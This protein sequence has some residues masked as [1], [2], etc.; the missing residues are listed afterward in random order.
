MSE[1]KAAGQAVE[2][3]ETFLRKY[4][5]YVRPL[6]AKLEDGRWLVKADVGALAV[7]IAK[8]TIDASDGRITDYERP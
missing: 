4:H 2:I 1:V 8:I 7:V 6:R 3:A 5:T